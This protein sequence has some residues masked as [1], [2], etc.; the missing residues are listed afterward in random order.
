VTKTKWMTLNGQNVLPAEIN[1]NSGTHQKKFN[2]DRHILSAA[3]C[4]SGICGYVSFNH[5]STEI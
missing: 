3:K 5:K 1:K 4:I 2:E